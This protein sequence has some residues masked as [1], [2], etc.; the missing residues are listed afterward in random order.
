MPTLYLTCGLPGAGKTTLAK[1]LEQEAHA[2]RLTGDD[3]M[4][5]LHPGISTPEAETGPWRSRVERL[6]WVIALRT[7]Q[8]GCNVVVDWGV[9]AKEERDLCRTSAREVGAR[10]VLCL[11]DPPIDELS[12]RL[13]LRNAQLP[14]GTFEISE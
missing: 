1:R 14:V 11:F 9:W 13:S 7:L 3:W 12:R 6:Q 10:V 8:L 2:L 4:H 5:E